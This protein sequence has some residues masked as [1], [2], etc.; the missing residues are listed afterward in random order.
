M[1]GREDDMIYLTSSLRVMVQGSK[2][3]EEERKEE[4][5]A[6]KRDRE[7]ELQRQGKTAGE[8]GKK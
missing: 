1:S 3:G 2:D 4:E 8:E 5:E 7:K 6:G